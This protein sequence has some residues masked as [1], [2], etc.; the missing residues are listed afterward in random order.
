MQLIVVSLL[1]QHA[2]NPDFLTCVP[3]SDFGVL[4]G[5]MEPVLEHPGP[6]WQLQGPLMR[7][8]WG[9]III[10]GAFGSF[11]G[12]PWDTL[13]RPL[14]SLGHLW[15][16]LDGAPLGPLR[17]PWAF[18]WGFDRHLGFLN[19]FPKGSTAV[20]RFCGL[21]SPRGAWPRI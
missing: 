17:A 12:R 6:F 2:K 21:H 3:N 7:A 10:L 13:A 1:H 15:S 19:G 18:S 8:R 11:L 5:S 16:S 4:V 9:P 14:D 20:D